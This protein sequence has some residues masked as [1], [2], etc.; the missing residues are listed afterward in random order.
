M[1]VE[2]IVFWVLPAAVLVATFAGISVMAGTAWPWTRIVHEDGVHTLLGTVFYFEHAAREL[3]P[4]TLLAIAVAGSVGYFF[5]PN[6]ALRA[7]DATRWRAR[8]GGLAAVSLAAILG[9][10]WWFDGGQAILDN[11][12]QLH[13]RAGAPL[14]WGA[15][16]RY[17]LLERLAQMLAAFSICGV[18]WL[19]R[20]KPDA[21]H[22]KG[23]FR[24]FGTALALFALTT[25]VFGLTSDPFRDPAYLG[26]QLRE[27][28]THG[29]VTLPLAMGA[30]L[31]L[32]RKFSSSRTTS[33]AGRIWP[34]VAAGGATVLIG[35]FLL[36]ASVLSDAQGHGQTTGLGAL[37]LPHFAEHTLGYVFVPALASFVYLWPRRTGL[38]R[39]GETAS[40]AV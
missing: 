4:D 19:L 7:A 11:L 8:T 32:A 25:I 40:P 38:A 15:H 36:V 17:H 20:G 29:L 30:C 13:T 9:G 18:I 33:S 1:R 14:V 26:H 34:I 2:R 21:R 28:F 10:T 35:A 37:L 3:V 23:R 16:W 22:V 39:A 27:L 5:P 24:L 12:S 31:E 6:D